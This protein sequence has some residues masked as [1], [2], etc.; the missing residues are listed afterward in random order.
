MFW[1]CFSSDLK[2]HLQIYKQLQAFCQFTKLFINNKH[3]KLTLKNHLGVF[4]RCLPPLIWGCLQRPY[5]VIHWIKTSYPITIIYRAVGMGIYQGSV[6]RSPNCTIHFTNPYPA[7]KSKEILWS[8]YE[9]YLVDNFIHTSYNRSLVDGAIQAVHSCYLS[10][11][12]KQ[13][14]KSFPLEKCFPLHR[15]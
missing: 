9:L 3:F 2:N 1:N 15:I 13:E 8:R 14:L 6:V 12:A 10:P 5:N 11:S 7:V 4:M